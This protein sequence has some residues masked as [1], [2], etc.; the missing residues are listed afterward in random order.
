MLMGWII[1]GTNLPTI[2]VVNALSRFEPSDPSDP[3]SQ[4][5]LTPRCLCNEFAMIEPHS[6][7]V[8]KLLLTPC[9]VKSMFL[10]FEYLACNTILKC[11]ILKWSAIFSLL[12]R[13]ATANL[14]VVNAFSHA[15]DVDWWKKAGL[16]MPHFSIWHF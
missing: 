14:A 2:S 12:S 8:F 15:S 16:L 11:F 3:Q 7:L 5:S 9:G 6:I 13:T 10:I 4:C 1:N